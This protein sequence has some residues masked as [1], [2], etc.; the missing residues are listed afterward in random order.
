MLL[1]FVGGGGWLWILCQEAAGDAFF[2]TKLLWRVWQCWGHD[3]CGWDSNVFFSGINDFVGNGIINKII[4]LY[5]RSLLFY[6]LRNVQILQL[7]TRQH[8]L[9]H[10]V[11]ECFAAVKY[12]LLLSDGSRLIQG[13]CICSLD[14]HSLF[15]KK[16]WHI[17]FVLFW[18]IW[19][20]FGIFRWFIQS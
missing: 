18:F 9:M 1:S 5:S 8:K 13:V 17:C 12:L 16:S 19:Q 14:F 2:C 20:N 6:C 11:L 10:I 3:E 4:L 15:F 7:F